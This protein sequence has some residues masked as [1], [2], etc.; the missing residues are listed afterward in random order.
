MN[1]NNAE[2]NTRR[3]GRPFSACARCGAP[4]ECGAA[5]G[6]ERCWCAELP[7]LTSPAPEASCYCPRCLGEIVGARAGD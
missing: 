2:E 7:A 3:S 5:A 6:L 4:F 1:R